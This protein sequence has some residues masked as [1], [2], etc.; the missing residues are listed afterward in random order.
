MVACVQY[1][2]LVLGPFVAHFRVIMQHPMDCEERL[3]SQAKAV[4]AVSPETHV[5]VYRNLVKA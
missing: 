1:M 5:W 4:K 2:F 3:V